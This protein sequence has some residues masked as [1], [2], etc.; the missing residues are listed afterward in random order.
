MT[1]PAHISKMVS[2][3]IPSFNQGEFIERTIQSVL[4]QDYRPIEIIVV[5][6]QSNDNTIEVLKKFIKTPE[7]RWISEPD[8]GH[9]D[10]INKGF[11]LAQGEIVAWL[12]SDDV[13]FTKNVIS[14]I[15][16]HFEKHP[17]H[18][19]VY[20]H[21]AIISRN[22]ILLRFYLVPPYDANRIKRRNLISQPSVF[23]RKDIV[24]NEK[25]AVGQIGLD[26][27]YW[28]RLIQKN[29]KF[30]RINK[31]LACDR[32]YAERL[33]VQKKLLIDSQIQDAKK[34]LGINNQVSKKVMYPFDRF[35][36]MI[37]RLIGVLY[38]I[39]VL[40]QNQKHA[41]AFPARIDS[42]K[43]LF[44]RQLLTSITHINT[45]Y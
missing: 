16:T 25:L 14:T 42:F 15:V 45:P 41:F 17:E 36:Q 22:D 33:S 38:I 37:Y 43:N 32:H 18:D 39:T 8:E 34:T 6:A 12:N 35:V 3:I 1:N 20:G 2:I 44:F 28:L 13:Y 11:Q 40:T 10:G 19:L 7:V 27:E 9:A 23:I 21:V 29:Y 31:I 4:L 24:K 30:F 5:D 26:Y